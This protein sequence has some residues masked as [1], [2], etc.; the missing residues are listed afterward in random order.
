[1][2]LCLFS[3]DHQHRETYCG[4]IVSRTEAISEDETQLNFNN[5]EAQLSCH[6][7]IAEVR[8]ARKHLEQVFARDH[9]RCLRGDYGPEVKA[10][11]EARDRN[12]KM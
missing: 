6:D 7:C 1:M 10:R 3:V 8:S 2:H 12:S 5:L 9:E 4:K 11:A